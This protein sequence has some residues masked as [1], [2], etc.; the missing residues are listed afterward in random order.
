MFSLVR[1]ALVMLSLLHSKRTIAK[2]EVGTRILLD[3]PGHAV[4]WRTMENFEMADYKSG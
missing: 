2:T 3:R 1:V 4:C